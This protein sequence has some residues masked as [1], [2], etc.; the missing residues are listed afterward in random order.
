VY[1]VRLAAGSRRKARFGSQC[2]IRER[3]KIVP[4]LRALGDPLT[5]GFKS[6]GCLAKAPK[7]AFLLRE[8]FG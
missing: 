2:A 1:P 5:C 8:R 7:G 4:P 6:H 3:T